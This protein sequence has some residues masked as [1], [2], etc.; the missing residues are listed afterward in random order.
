MSS[1]AAPH[2]MPEQHERPVAAPANTPDSSTLAAAGRRPASLSLKLAIGLALTLAG[3]ASAHFLVGTGIHLLLHRLMDAGAAYG[4][5]D[6]AALIFMTGL[7]LTILYGV[8]G[9]LEIA[10]ERRLTKE[11]ERTRNELTQAIETMSEAFVLFDAD[12]RLVICNR[13]FKALFPRSLHLIEPGLTFEALIRHAISVAPPRTAAGRRGEDWVRER[14][15]RH[16]NPLIPE[17]IQ[18]DDGRWIKISERRT[19]DGGYVGIRTDITRLKQVEHELQARVT[20]LEETKHRLETQGKEL[21][22][23]RD[24]AE[25]A[26]Q[27]KSDFLATMSHEIRTPMNGVLGMAAML[28]ESPLDPEQRSYAEAIRELG[29][30]LLDIVNDILDFSKL[31]ADKVVLEHIPFDPV[32]LIELVANLLAPRAQAKG[33]RIATYVAP[34]VPRRLM[35]DPGRL[36]QVLI[37]LFGNAIKFTERGAV[38]VTARRKHRPDGNFILHV[39]VMDTGIGI[40]EDVQ[41]QLFTRFTQAD[42]STSRRYGGTGLGLAISRRI[43]E[44]MNGA[45]GVDSRPDQ[46]SR[47]WFRVELGV[48]PQQDAAPAA[49]SGLHVLVIDNEPV[50]RNLIARQLGDWQIT[51]DTAGSLGDALA[52]LQAARGEGHTFDVILVDEH[53]VS[54]ERSAS[55]AEAIRQG[56]VT[57]GSVAMSAIADKPSP[58][59]MAEHAF[60]RWLARPVHEVA[61]Y[62]CIADLTGRAEARNENT[63]VAPDGQHV[64]A[65]ELA[66]LRNDRQPRPL[67]ILVAE[68]NHVNQMLVVAMLGKLG[69]HADVAAN[70]REAVEAVRQGSYD[71]VLMDVMMPEMDGFEATAAIRHLPPPRN[72]I[73]I[74]ALTA[75]A[76][77]G[78]DKTCLAMGMDD[79]LAKPL[80]LAR[81]A[82]VLKRRTRRRISDNSSRKAVA[83]TAPAGMADAAPLIDR[84]VIDLLVATVGRDA[85]RDLIETYRAELARILAR[86]D[87][88]LAGDDV[89]ALRHA[90]HDL[91]STS[92]SFGAFGLHDLSNDVETA[93]RDN[94]Y[95]GATAHV[96]ELRRLAGQVARMLGLLA[97]ELGD[98]A[99]ETPARRVKTH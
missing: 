80:D 56:A 89:A 22:Q 99:R 61:L 12:D 52:R 68:D 78:E 71:L 43:I 3:A 18:L 84:K 19:A 79:Y 97:A 70:G 30:A 96:P 8:Y 6:D 92:G 26:N 20:E 14:V 49:L 1:G 13:K 65:E 45:I 48:A 73:P 17:E 28:L 86:I 36:R 87:K 46:G 83:A 24:A 10:R 42:A 76:L 54:G 29:E 15:E 82:Q 21:I 59:W 75:N 64:T 67:D 94:D 93:A 55:L 95:V 60:T 58:E 7:V 2:P 66:L 33:L 85:T 34:D 40:A 63:A 98:E 11:L 5:G 74:V 88:A 31:E 51:V 81:L 50:T 27:A 16:L 77:Q 32:D 62:N 23:A 25:R 41:S 37:N 4:I 72:R 53:A 39:D 38:T 57:S 35:G 47:F 91:K 69:H 9:A 44:A 90:A